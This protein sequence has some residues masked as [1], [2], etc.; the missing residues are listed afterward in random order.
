MTHVPRSISRRRFLQGA[1]SAALGLVTAPLGALDTSAP[2]DIV[3]RGGSILDGDGGTAW[4][5]DIGIRGDTIAA[6]GAIAP[7]QGAQ[8]LDASGLVVAPG[9]IDIHSHSDDPIIRYPRA[10]SRVLQ[11]ITTELTGNCGYS[12]AP[13][14]GVNESA[15][16]KAFRDN[17]GLDP[18]WTDVASYLEALETLGISINQALLLGQGSLRENVI[19]GA[20][21]ALTEKEMRSL[22][23]AVQEGMEQ[24]AFGLSTGLEYEPGIFTPTPEIIAMA[25]I[26]ARNGGLYASHIRNEVATVLGAVAEAIEIGRRSETRVQVSHL[27]AVGA[28][29]WSKQAPALE[30]LETARERGLD[31]LADAYPYT[32]YSTILTVLTPAWARD[33]GQ[34]ALLGRLGDPAQRARIRTEVEHT[35]SEDPGG[36]DLIVISSVSTERNRDLIGSNLETIAERRSIAP[37]EALLRL[38]EEENGNVSYVGHGMSEANVELVLAHPQVMIGSDGEAM[39]PE[40]PAAEKRPHPR[41]YGTYPRVL[42]HYCRERR[43][44]DLPTAIRKM[45]SM[46]ADQ[47]GL[48]DRGRIARGKKADLVL[49]DA[50]E[51]ADRA[52]FQQPHRYSAGINHVLVNGQPVVVDGE[53]TGRRPGRALRSS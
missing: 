1:S 52:T 31:V 27:K 4:S 41:A 47:I 25:R 20:D 50:A 29:N 23:D 33:G 3:I 5:A 40:G 10:E 19:G 21:R 22:L 45:T 16:R 17:L 43:L 9:F 11:G 13:L 48:T 14:A 42:G 49:F 26:V 39:A 7:D 37:I 34:D 51:V 2:F 24:G 8:L 44:F 12:A 18:D 46:P 32:A 30:L 35:V 6:L 15:R 28:P 36:F 38:L 53:H